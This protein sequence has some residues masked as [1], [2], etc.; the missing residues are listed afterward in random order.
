MT[1][2]VAQRTALEAAGAIVTATSLALPEEIEWEDYQALGAFIGEMNRACAWWAGDLIVYGENVYGEIHSQIDEVLGL[3]PQ[4][5]ANRA[6]VARHIPPNRRRASLPF[7]VSPRWRTWNPTSATV[8]WIALSWGSGREQ[9]CAMRF[10]SH[11][12]KSRSRAA[13]WP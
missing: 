6:S 8:G 5:I 11:E 9:C 4:T 12:A 13:I 10:V 2:E 3:A 1:E 7:G